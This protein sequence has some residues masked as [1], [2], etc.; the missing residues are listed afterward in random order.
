MTIYT[1]S[2]L[3]KCFQNLSKS[4]FESLKI[5]KIIKYK[6]EVIKKKIDRSERAVRIVSGVL[7]VVL[8]CC[9]VF[10]PQIEKIFSDSKQKELVATF[11]QLAHIE[12]STAIEV[13]SEQANEQLELLEGAIGIIRIPEIDLEMVIFAGANQS[14]LK[15]GAG[16]IEP[17]KKIGVNN[18]GI[19][20]H[21]SLA[22]G[23]HFNRLGELAANDEIEIMTKDGTFAFVVADTFVVDQKEVGVL[24]DK[25]DPLITLVTCTP[26]GKKNPTDRLIVQ[27]KL[28]QSTN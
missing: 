17:E 27:G 4:F 20:G 8:G 11:E 25:D 26:I 6:N 15:N 24:T 14:S 5:L 13:D 18:V 2:S 19:A 12:E 23:K 1:I 22:H 3:V 21:R 16:T 10:Y 28:K 9:L 7:L